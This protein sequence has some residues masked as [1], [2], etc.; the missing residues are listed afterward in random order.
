VRDS[1]GFQNVGYFARRLKGIFVRHG[2]AS[3]SVISYR[4][5]FL[6]KEPIPYG[7]YVQTMGSWTRAVFRMRRFGHHERNKFEENNLKDW[8]V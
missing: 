5:G 3:R 2:E 7:K 4:H 6:C 1:I 8:K